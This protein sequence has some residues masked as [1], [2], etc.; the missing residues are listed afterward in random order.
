M[1]FKSQYGQLLE[2]RNLVRWYSNLSKGSV[3]VAQ[4]YLRRLG[5]F[6]KQVG[7]S[8]GEYVKLSLR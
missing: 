8:P 3:I 6:C 1:G 7:I 2:D 5:S 4:V